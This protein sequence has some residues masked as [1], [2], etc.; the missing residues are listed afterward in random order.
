MFKEVI[1][2]ARKFATEHHK[3]QFDKAGAAYINHPATVAKFVEEMGYGDEYI[4]VAWLHDV[5]EDCNVS[6][7]DIREIFGD[8]IANAVD[9]VTKRKP[10]GE[11]YADYMARVKANPIATVVKLC[12]YKHNMD[13]GR[14]KE[15]D[16]VAIDRYNKYAKNSVKLWKHKLKMGW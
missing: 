3:N 10:E 14:L 2:K 7:D 5:V 15:V 6:V 1:D 13:L 12:D 16:D 4:T 9:A 8:C 11:K